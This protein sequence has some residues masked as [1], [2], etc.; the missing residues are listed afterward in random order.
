M[1]HLFW[2]PNW[3]ETS[4]NEFFLKLSNAVSGDS[5]VLDGN[6]SRTNSIKWERADTVVWIDF[7]FIRT[8]SQLLKRTIMR[9]TTR[10]ELWSGTGNKETFYKSFMS[11]DSILVWFFKSYRK[12]RSRYSALMTSEEYEHIKW[13][14]LR[15]P[16]EV[17]EFLECR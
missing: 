7:G 11:K 13:Y 14:R 3:E 5:W 2:K 9:A 17:R 12:N 4:D 1:D 15:S 8:F 6:Y 16:R 10:K